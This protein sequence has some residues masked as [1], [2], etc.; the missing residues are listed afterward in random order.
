MGL[1]VEDCMYRWGLYGFEFVDLGTVPLE[2]WIITP[3]ITTFPFLGPFRQR[4]K[5]GFSRHAINRDTSGMLFLSLSP[6]LPPHIAGRQ[7]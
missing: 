1:G 7:A 6:I 5:N 3:P 4:H 2:Q